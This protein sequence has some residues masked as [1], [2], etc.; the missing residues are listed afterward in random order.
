MKTLALDGDLRQKVVALLGRAPLFRELSPA[1]FENV[2]AR[3]HLVLFDPGETLVREGEASG[4]M[5]LLVQGEASVRVPEKRTGEPVDVGRLQ[6][7][8]TVGEMGLLLRQPRSATVT[9][10]TPVF[11]L[12]LETGPF[13]AMFTELPGF[14]LGMAR[15][16]ALRLRHTTRQIPLPEWDGEVSPSPKLMELLPL[17]FL[18]RHRVLPLKLDGTVLTLGFVGETDPAVLSSA[19]QMLPSLQLRPVGV[20]ARAFDA[21][22]SKSAAVPEWTAKAPGSQP[23]VEAAPKDEGPRSSPALDALL[24]RMVAEGASDLHLSG[25]HKPRWRIDGEIRSIEDAAELGRETVLEMVQPIMDQRARDAFAEHDADFA[26]AIQGLARFRVNVFRDH[27]GVG[28]V[29]RV[30]PDKILTFEQLGLPHVLQS[31]CEQPKGLVLVTGPTGSGKSTTL[32]AMID[33][34]N[35]TRGD[36]IITMEDPIEFV[37]RSQ[38]SLVNQREVGPHTKSFARALR[39]ALRE[40]PDIV[41]V[42]E[43]RDLETVSL[44]LETANTGHLVFGTLHT[45]TAPSTIDRIIN[46]FPPAQQ[47]QVRNGLGDM[48][49]GVIAQTLCKRVGGGRIAALEVLVCNLAVANL[50]RDGKIHQIP[51]VMSTGKAQGNMLLNEELARLVTEKKVAYEEASA[52]AVDKIDLAKRCGREPP[53]EVR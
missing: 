51:P 14:G 25:G 33:Q 11:A 36:H 2:L 5:F 16:L 10:L 43:M 9:A 26:Y 4:D 15:A 1:H 31:L 18:E 34:I 40:D 24:R 46:L 13:E 53:R 12:R 30:I 42:G 8:E 22:L 44:A 32:A 49:R 21:V 23:A 37:H 29:L 45:S 50:I 52:K 17:A 20:S 38:R 41:L 27:R 28:S 35:R 39:A 3:A 47:T 7:P 6:S 48:L 19:R